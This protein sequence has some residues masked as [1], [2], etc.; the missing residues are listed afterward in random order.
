LENF[1]LLKIDLLEP[2]EIREGKLSQK[3]SSRP[4]TAFECFELG[5]VAY[6][7]DDSYHTVIWMSEALTQFQIETNSSNHSQVK[8]FDILDYLAFATAQ[9][10][11]FIF[12]F[13]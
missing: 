9:Q 10:G 8:E 3:Y 12:N 6:E 4:L 2:S 11:K 13:H 1:H 5:R 7:E